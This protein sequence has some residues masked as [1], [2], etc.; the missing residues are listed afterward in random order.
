[1]FQDLNK[2][3]KILENNDENILKCSHKIENNELVIFPTENVFQIGCN[4]FSTNA[5]K[6]IYKIKNKNYNKPLTLNVLDY[7]MAQ[8]FIQPNN[9]EKKI[10]EELVSL[11]WPGPLTFILKNK[12]KKLND[13][14]QTKNDSKQNEDQFNNL[15]ITCPENKSIRTIIEKTFTPLF[16]SSANPCGKIP[17]VT[18]SH[19][20]KYFEKENITLLKGSHYPKYCFENT[21]LSI[22]NNY[23]ESNKCVLIVEQ[24]GLITIEMLKNSLSDFEIE[25]ID[26][27]DL[28][29]I[30]KNKLNFNNDNDKNKKKDN[31][32][33]SNLGSKKLDKKIIFFNFMESSHIKLGDFQEN[34]IQSV[35]NYLQNSALVDFNSLNFKHRNKFGAYVD[36]SEK[37]DIKEAI[38]N[39][40]NV[41]HQLI[42][43]KEIQNILIYNYY[44]EKSELHISLSN[45]INKFCNFSKTII[46]LF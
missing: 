10:I 35:N 19:V 40:Y 1:M 46:P 27:V 3:I 22:C 15:F 44:E 30:Q 5:I 36:L 9:F 24:R 4:C 45:K 17:S 25:I 8:N 21:I 12:S 26:R 29:K 18:H 31:N 28:N 32:F 38:F 16:T 34:I 20:L 43:C 23:F 37:G 6:N 42:E 13:L 2:N 7:E 11:F 33:G 41:I 14:L 39:F